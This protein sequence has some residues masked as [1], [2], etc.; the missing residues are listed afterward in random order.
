VG[1]QSQILIKNIHWFP[2]TSSRA[3][4]ILRWCLLKWRT[5]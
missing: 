1:D 5:R 3:A 2:S 4:W